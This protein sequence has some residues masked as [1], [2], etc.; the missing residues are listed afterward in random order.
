MPS[1]TLTLEQFQF[2]ETGVL[3]N[4]D[5]TLPFVDIESIEGLDNAP[6]RVQTH[7]MEGQDGGYV[8]SEFESMRTV[9]LEGTIY[10]SPTALET[11]LDSLKANFAPHTTAKP[12]F[13]MT[14]AGQRVV[15]GKSQGLRYRK[16]SDRRLG[17]ASF[18]V[19][20]MCEDPRI[21]TDT[22]ISQTATRATGSVVV[23][24]GGNRTTPATITLTGSI[25]GPTVT[26]VESGNVFAFTGYV[27]GAGQSIVI[28]LNNRTVVQAGASKRNLM[29]I[30][31]TWYKLSPGTNTFNFGG[32]GSSATIKVE[33]RSAWR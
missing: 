18:Q 21:Y 27:L 30:T 6:Y 24:P 10:A 31:G 12:L 17:K 1:P 29:T 22:L 20:I 8:D 23:S 28:D 2:E 13:F 7:D 3:L 25:T 11:Y 5:S 19:Q 9:G 4:G 26:H 32:T 16:D 14:D 15:F 33:T